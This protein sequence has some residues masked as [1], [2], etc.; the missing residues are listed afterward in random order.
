MNNILYKDDSCLVVNKLKGEAVEGSKEGIV[1]LPL[2]L[3]KELNIDFIEAVNRLDVPITGCALFALNASSLE[4][5]NAS[6]ADNSG[7]DASKR[8][9]QKIVKKYWA[10]TEKPAN[11]PPEKGRLV[12]WIETNTRTNKSFA[13]NEEGKNRK[14]STLGYCIKGKGTNYLFIEIE[15]HSGRHHQIRA[16]LAVIGLHI[17]GDLK[18]GAKRSEKDGGIRLHAR[19]LSFPDPLNKNEQIS[20]T[21]NPPQIDNLW[22]AFMNA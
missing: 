20:V 6:F 7:K 14:K 11:Y 5:L 15:L 22:E 17:K 12:H 8:S 9:A 10:I 3:K 18:Y 21:A 1:N 19:F 16:Q 4:F 13:Y 2:E